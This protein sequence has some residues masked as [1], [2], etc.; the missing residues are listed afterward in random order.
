MTKQ[1]YNM[2]HYIL[3]RCI[4]L[5]CWEI[6]LGLSTIGVT[7][8]SLVWKIRSEM[9]SL[10]SKT[11]ISC[12]ACL[13]LCN[14]VFA[15]NGDW[16]NSSG[17]GVCAVKGRELQRNKGYLTKIWEMSRYVFVR[18]LLGRLL[19]QGHQTWQGGRGWARKKSAEVRFH[20]N[21]F[22]AMISRKFS[23]GQDISAR[24]MIFCI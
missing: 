21:D 12:G 18:L 17:T 20:G 2:L 15:S 13:A 23:H 7:T 9:S 22:V 10:S 4:S 16:V 5:T 11:R 1:N 14:V 8:K 24:V 19:V 3:L 6:T